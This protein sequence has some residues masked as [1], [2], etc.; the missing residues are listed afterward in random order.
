MN[1]T[2]YSKTEESIGSLAK[3][4]V[5]AGFKCGLPGAIILP[6]FL[7]TFQASVSALGFNLQHQLHTFKGALYTP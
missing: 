1:I 5:E 6:N 2:T 4:F 3:S 7:H